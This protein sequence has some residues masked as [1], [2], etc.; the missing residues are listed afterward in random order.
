MAIKI[1]QISKDFNMKSKDVLDMF[2]EIGLEKKSGA[3][4]QD[5]EYE[6]FVHLATASHQI[7]NIDDYID[8]KTKITVAEEKAAESKAEEKPVLVAPKAEAKPAPAPVK[9]EVKVE[10]KAAPAPKAEPAP[11]K[12]EVKV[13][14]A[15]KA[16]PA[17]EAK[18][19]A[20]EADAADEKK[21]GFF[22][23]L[24]GKK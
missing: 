6:L 8:G 15:P 3:A 13:E 5:D 12:E 2:K 17:P 22:G 9:E 11:V 10:V 18:E 1:T 14:T 24:F 16:E 4:I 21:K 19:E 20:A 23:R 7:K